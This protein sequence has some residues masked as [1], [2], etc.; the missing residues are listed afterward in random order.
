[1][2][3]RV[4]I[5]IGVA[6]VIV[7]LAVAGFYSCDDQKQGGVKKASTAKQVGAADPCAEAVQI[8]KL[9]AE[10]NRLNSE[11]AV[12]NAKLIDCLESKIP[13]QK[14]STTTV[15]KPAAA[16][17][18]STPSKVTTP[19]ATKSAVPPTTTTLKSGTPGLAN[20]DYLRQGGEIIYCVRANGR[21]DCYFPHYAMNQGVMFSRAPIDN[22]IKGYNFKVEPT[23]V[24]E[25]DYGVTFDGTFYI[26][27]ELIQ[28]SLQAG[29]LAFTGQVEIKCPYTG[30]G[31]KTM[32]KSGNYWI[33]ATQK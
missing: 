6:I 21:E 31:L 22:Q 8:A 23:E 9:E 13:A 19:A 17:P 30:W 3:R 33:F 4:F 16:T 14:S 28:K 29:G 24:Y 26:S 18:A 10:V 25:G 11:L 15:R 32:T 1:M 27:D 12:A 5:W 2:N 7:V 20:L